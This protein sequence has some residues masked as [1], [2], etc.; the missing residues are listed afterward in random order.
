M[1][2]VAADILAEQVGPLFCP[3]SEC[4]S[5]MGTSVTETLSKVTS[6]KDPF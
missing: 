4:F 3:A 6:P 2:K 5:L 1:W